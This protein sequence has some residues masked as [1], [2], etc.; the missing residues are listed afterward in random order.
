ML[1]KMKLKKKHK[2]FRLNDIFYFQTYN[3]N[4]IT[5]DFLRA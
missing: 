2:P 1:G 4:V 3:K 5:G